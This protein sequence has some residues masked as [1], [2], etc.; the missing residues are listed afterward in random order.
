MS[1]GRGQDARSGKSPRP[2]VFED[3]AP[4][5]AELEADLARRVAL[6]GEGHHLLIAFQPCTATFPLALLFCKGT[7]RGPERS[8]V[9]CE[10]ACGLTQ[11]S[12]IARQ[13]PFKGVPGLVGLVGTSWRQ[14]LAFRKKQP[15]DLMSDSLDSPQT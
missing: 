10:Q 4:C 13:A 7:F 2:Q 1:R 6:L 8:V 3:G 12:M 14:Y 9:V 5:H 11:M 15:N